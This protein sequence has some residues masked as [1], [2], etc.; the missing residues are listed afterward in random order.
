MAQNRFFI[1]PETDFNLY[2]EHLLHVKVE[3]CRP[4]GNGDIVVKLPLGDDT[5]AAMAHLQEYTDATLEPIL[6]VHDQSDPIVT[7]Q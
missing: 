2:S 4:V 1:I 3:D 7:A 5:P 6:A